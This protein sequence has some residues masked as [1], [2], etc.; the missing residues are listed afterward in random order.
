[1]GTVGKWI[2]SGV[3]GLLGLLGLFVAE[4]AHSGPVY[5]AGL[6]LFAVAV[7]FIMYQIRRAYDLQERGAG[8]G[9]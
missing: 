8:G 9:S 2:L 1:M 3:V 5:Y 7:G 4:G 6:L